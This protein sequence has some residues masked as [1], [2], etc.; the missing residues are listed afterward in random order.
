MHKHR[1]FGYPALAFLLL[2]VAGS[3]SAQNIVPNPGF[4]T[5]LIPWTQFLSSAPDP[6]G[7]GAAP[8]WIPVDINNSPSSGAGQ[9]NIDATTPAGD[10]ASGI[11]Q[12]VNF[13]AA[14]SINFVNYGMSFRVPAATTGD[15]AINATVEVRLF[16][17]A[18]CSGFITGGS[19][20][21]D[22]LA[23]L[24]SDTNWYTVGDTSLAPPG[25]PVMAASA[26]FRAYLREVNGVGPTTASYTVDYD[27]AHL[28][29]N[30]TTPVRLQQFDVE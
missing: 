6:N 9:V 3:V 13:A 10:A 8:I 30:S 12:C 21:R 23:G 11:V 22:L 27:A 7:A 28:I 19:Q 29:L 1:A 24:P 4:D 16:S 18:G 17:S 14:T 20:G 2:A 5:T 25:A 26:E 15:G